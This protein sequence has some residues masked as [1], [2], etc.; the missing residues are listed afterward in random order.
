MRTAYAPDLPSIQSGVLFF[1]SV[2]ILVFPFRS[3]EAKLNHRKNKNDHE[4]D[5]RH[6][7]SESQI[8]RKAEGILVDTQEHGLSLV[9]RSAPREQ[10]EDHKNLKGGNDR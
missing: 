6:G 9:L 4:Q 1:F 3:P 8:I 10:L 5:H 7:G 2:F